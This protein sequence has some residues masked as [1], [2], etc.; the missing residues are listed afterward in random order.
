MFE[1]YMFHNNKTFLK[2]FL[3]ISL[4]FAVIISAWKTSPFVCLYT[5]FRQTVNT[6]YCRIIAP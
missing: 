6:H 2:T 3:A 4:V 5:V 1:V